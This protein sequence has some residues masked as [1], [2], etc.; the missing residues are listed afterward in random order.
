MPMNIYQNESTNNLVTKCYE[1]IEKSIIS[2][3]FTPQKKL[4]IKELKEVTQCGPTP[5]REALSRLITAGL[6]TAK[7]N[8]GFYVA[9]VS[10]QDIRDVYNTFL[11]I[12]TA[13]LTQAILSGD[14][15]WKT[16]I[17][18]A[19]YN[20]SLLETAPQTPS[21]EIWL[22][23]NYDFHLSLIAGCNSPALLQLRSAIYRKFDR[24]C[25]LAFN[26]MDRPLSMNYKEHEE[27]AS[28]VLNRDIS[29]AKTLMAHHIMEPLEN[30]IMCLKNKALL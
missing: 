23:K 21:L 30:I 8:R 20:L 9:Q 24:Y 3:T 18:A 13:A 29:H 1:I 4:K 7:D 26:T 22:Q 25:Q 12:E 27:L 2:G 19:L 28:A 17:V 16:S 5:I 6:V 15:Q 10:E 14:D 11:L